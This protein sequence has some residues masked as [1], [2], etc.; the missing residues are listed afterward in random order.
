MRRTVEAARATE[1]PPNIQAILK[2]RAP[3][4]AA[5]GQE[6]L[7]IDTDE[8]WARVAYSLGE[9]HCNRYGAIH[10]G[11]IACIMDDVVATAAG[12]AAQW[13]EIAPT[14][15][16]KVS[17]LNPVAMGPHVAE[18]RVVKR[19]RSILFVEGMLCDAEGKTLATASATIMIAPLKR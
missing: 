10:G 4:S 18:A 16:M 13:G 19:G 14:L 17:Y 11:A 6:V 5:L 7:E 3:A 9:T 15:E 1:Y 8:G 12:L 2:R